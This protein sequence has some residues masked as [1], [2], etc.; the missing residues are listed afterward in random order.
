M[1][2]NRSK[3]ISKVVEECECIFEIMKS[4][5]ACFTGHRSQKLPWKF[6]E[7]DE[8]CVAMRNKA[9][10]L[11]EKAINIGYKNFIS[12]MALGFDTICAELVLELKEKYPHIRLVCAIPCKTQSAPWHENQKIRYQSILKQADLI[13]Y[14][15]NEY[16]ENCMLE[17]NEYMINN[18]SL[19]IALYNG[20]GGGT[21]YTVRRAKERNLELLIIEP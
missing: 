13:R 1:C 20:K 21:G 18:S 12:G 17:R 4:E 14:I 11:I 15:S 6:N 16:T 10:G 5:T 3:K 8:R 7:N 19:V 9:K 2:T